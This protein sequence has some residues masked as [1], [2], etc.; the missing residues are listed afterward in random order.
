MKTNR[1]RPKESA[2][3]KVIRRIK[4]AAPVS[5]FDSVECANY[6][7]PDSSPPTHLLCPVCTEVYDSPIE[8]PCEQLICAS[9]LC[10]WVQHAETLA[11]PCCY[12]EHHP[13]LDE[14]EFRP[15]N[16]VLLDVLG[17]LLVAC[18]K[19]CQTLVK[20]KDIS[21]H[22][23]S[24]CKGYIEM[25]QSSPSRTTIR[26]VLSRPADTPTTPIE[27]R[28]AEHL[29]RR[30]QAESDECVVRIPTRGQVTKSTHGKNSTP[31]C[32][33]GQHLIYMFLYYVYLPADQ[34]SASV[35][36]PCSKFSC[37]Q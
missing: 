34:L 35:Q 19:G 11:C 15:P 31:A 25:T 22:I 10:T 6:H 27:K 5:L 20:A 3:T 16:S 28:A 13:L 9:C 8:L 2:T 7:P 4:S 33:H 37:Y 24:G 14:V 17:S 23:S 32:A 12:N 1:G 21:I 29:I 26:D 36:L 30:L 18:N